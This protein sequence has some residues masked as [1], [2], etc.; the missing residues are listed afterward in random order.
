[1]NTDSFRFVGYPV[2]VHAGPDSINSLT[3]EL[4]RINARRALVVCG[5]SVANKTNLVDRVNNALGDRVAEVFS[6]G[7]TGSPLPSVLEG[8]SVAKK[9]GVDCVVAVGG[10]SAVVTARGITILLAENGTAQ[11]LCT[12]YPEGEPPISPRLIA[13]KIPNFV[14]LTLSLIHI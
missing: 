6:G 11:E 12:Q 4:D 13:P 14:V 7:K 5:D 8:V 10:G 9:A 3:G 2:R 1:M